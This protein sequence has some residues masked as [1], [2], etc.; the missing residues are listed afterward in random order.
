[1]LLMWLCTCH[2]ISYSHCGESDHNK[3]DCI[4]CGPAFNVFEDDSRDGDEDDAAS[5]DEQ[6]DGRHPDF[7]LADLFVFLLKKTEKRHY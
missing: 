1:M 7:C 3:V 5:Q 6:D 2:V 4:Q